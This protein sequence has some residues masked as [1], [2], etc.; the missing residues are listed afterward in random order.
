MNVWRLSLLISVLAFTAMGQQNSPEQRPV[1]PASC[2][3]TLAPAVRFTPP[4]LH[5][6]GKDDS[7]FWL[8]TEKLWTP[9]RNQERSGGGPRVHQA[10]PT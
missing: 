6:M 3:V 4:G 2:P 10:T 1:A 8:G 5:E 7:D 9:F